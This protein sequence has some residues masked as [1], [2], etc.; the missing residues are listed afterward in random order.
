MHW[1]SP[2]TLKHEKNCA[3][4]RFPLE[5]RDKKAGL[6]GKK[7]RVGKKGFKEEGKGKK[8]KV[9]ERPPMHVARGEK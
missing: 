9:K 2:L 5:G 3:S 6:I 7:P 8:A 1:K 4:R